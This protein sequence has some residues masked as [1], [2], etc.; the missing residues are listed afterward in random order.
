MCT[1]GAWPGSDGASPDSGL[2][3]T[4][5]GPPRTAAEALAMMD[6]A[7]DFLNGEFL[8]GPGGA[9]LAGAGLGG[10]LESLGVLSAKFAAARAAVLARFD[11]ARGHDADGYGSSAAWL[12]AK[13]R[14]TRK[15][16]NTEVR[17][18]RQFRAHPVIAAAVARGE[19][20]QDWAAEIADWTRKLPPDWRDDV[21]TLLAG[22]AA[23]GAEL[24][25]LAVVAQAA[26][27]KWRQ[28]QGPDD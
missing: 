13:G 3:G 9:G 19:L 26:Y 15:A 12:A 27:E 22:T 10:V 16:A 20:S 6:A 1:D 11:A 7:L 23:A 18:M 2:P 4:G 28:Q 24:A 8:A 17:R 21:D 25:D 5:S 14:T